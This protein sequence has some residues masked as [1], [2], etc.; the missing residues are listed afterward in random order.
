MYIQQL[1][2]GG[3]KKLSDLGQRTQLPDSTDNA[4]GLKRDPREA[5]TQ[6]TQLRS[7]QTDAIIQGNTNT[8]FSMRDSTASTKPANIRVK[9]T[10]QKSQ[11]S[12]RMMKSVMHP[13]KPLTQGGVVNHV[14][15]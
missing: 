13:V 11:Q 9:G 10:L 4:S 8:R 15:S 12:Q 2:K 3:I 14:Q 1:N 5:S 7:M 6:P